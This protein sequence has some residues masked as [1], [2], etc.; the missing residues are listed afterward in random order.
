[1]PIAYITTVIYKPFNFFFL[2]NIAFAFA[3]FVE[4]ISIFIIL[5]KL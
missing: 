5:Y 1:M 2:K 4:C 3:V